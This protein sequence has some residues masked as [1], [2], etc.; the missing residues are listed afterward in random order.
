MA[1]INRMFYR[2][3]YLTACE[4]GGKIELRAQALRHARRY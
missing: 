4:F 2:A 1:L 3:K